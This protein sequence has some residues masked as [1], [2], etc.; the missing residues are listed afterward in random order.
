MFIHEIRTVEVQNGRCSVRN[1]TRILLL[2]ETESF[3]GDE[4][5][6]M[7]LGFIFLIAKLNS[8]D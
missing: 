5:T 4:L 1:F 7:S 6:V 2:R 3:K 8:T